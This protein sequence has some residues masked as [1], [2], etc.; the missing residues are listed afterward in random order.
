MSRE[1]GNV[2]SVVLYHDILSKVIVHGLGGSGRPPVGREAPQ[3]RLV[4]QLYF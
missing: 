2:L 4:R 1:Y 3:A